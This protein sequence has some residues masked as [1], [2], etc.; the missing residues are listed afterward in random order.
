MCQLKEVVGD[1][2]GG[3]VVKYLPAHAGDRFDPWSRKIPHV[4]GKLLKP[5]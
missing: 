2:P 3:Q 5:V 1:F 4:L